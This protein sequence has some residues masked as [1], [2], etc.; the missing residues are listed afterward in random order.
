MGLDETA[1]FAFI[2]EKCVKILKTVKHP[3]YVLEDVEIQHGIVGE[4]CQSQLVLINWS[5][6]IYVQE[7]SAAWKTN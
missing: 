6:T 2:A 3:S 5:E 4:L 1:S 7:E